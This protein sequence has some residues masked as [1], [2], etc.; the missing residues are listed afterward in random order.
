MP[1]ANLVTISMNGMTNGY[2][3]FIT[4]LNA[5]EKALVFE[6]LVGILMQE[7]ERQLTHKPQSSDLAL[8]VKKKPFRGNPNAAQKSSVAQ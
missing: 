7:E 5:R 6:E 2:Q 3:M 1:D 4:S 8:M